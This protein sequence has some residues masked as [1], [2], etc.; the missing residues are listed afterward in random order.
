[1][2][3]LEPNKNQ[4]NHIDLYRMPHRPEAVFLRASHQVSCKDKAGPF[5]GLGCTLLKLNAGSQKWKSF[6]LS[7]FWQFNSVMVGCQLMVL[8]T[9]KD[10]SLSKGSF[11]FKS[12]VNLGSHSTLQSWQQG[13]FHFC[14]EYVL[15]WQLSDLKQSAAC[16]CYLCGANVWST[17]HLKWKIFRLANWISG[18]LW[19]R[20]TR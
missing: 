11:I 15:L 5:L 10:T 6:D 18:T 9:S 2:F 7:F 8:C 14:V 16:S 17:E 13:E 20:N 19:C 1:M 4:R 12:G 3:V